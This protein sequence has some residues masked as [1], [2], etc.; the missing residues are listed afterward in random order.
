MT[1]GRDPAVFQYYAGHGVQHHPLA[2]AGRINALVQPCLREREARDR[3]RVAGAHRLA[4]R[5]R[6]GVFTRVSA[7]AVAAPRRPTRCHARA[8]R[9]AL[10]RLAGL[11]SRRGDFTAWEYLFRYGAGEPPWISGM[12]QATAAQ[13]L[14]R[15]AEALDVPRY[16]RMAVDALGAF[17]A[18]PPLGVAIPEA[19]GRHYVMYSFDPGLRILNGF[20]QSVI[21]LHDVAELTGSR[22]ALRLFRLGERTARA[23]VDAYDTGAWSLYSFAG[24]E[25][26]L[27]YHELVTN[28]L[29][30]MCRRT[31][32][33]HYCAPERRFVRYLHEPPA[34]SLVASRRLVRF[35]V[36]KVSA[37]SVSVHGPRFRLSRRLSVARGR[38]SV[39]WAPRRAGRYI[40]SVAATGPEGRRAVRRT[41]VRIKPPP[42]PRPIELSATVRQVRAG[43]GH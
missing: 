40:V 13:A 26:P 15:G 11:A 1:F 29:G 24:R 4:L 27:S 19:G 30:G 9:R 42:K 10:N 32:N 34:L 18:A 33:P 28:F 37:V 23:S 38:W 43:L 35:R 25:S 39:A 20:L 41:V 6:M 21:G 31:G 12:A 36:S 2:T 22:R 8:L 14:A 3:R 7:V 5:R 17:D 16:R